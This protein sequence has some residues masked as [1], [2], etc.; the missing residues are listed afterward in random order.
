VAIP[1]GIVLIFFGLVWFLQGG[2]VLPGSFMT[3]SEFW[4]IAGGITLVIG[5]VLIGVGVRDRK[6]QP[7]S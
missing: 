1:V 7:T 5:L 6:P 2:D 4:A 3:G